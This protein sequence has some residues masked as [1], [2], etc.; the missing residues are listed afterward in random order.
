MKGV[1]FLILSLVLS[2]SGF[3]IYHGC[4]ISPSFYMWVCEQESSHCFRSLD[5]GRTWY[6]LGRP[7]LT[8]RLLYDIFF[9][10]DTLGWISA[11]GGYIFYTNDGGESWRTQ[12]QGGTKFAQRIFMLNERLGWIASGEAII[13]K[14]TNGGEEWEQIILPNPPFPADTVD[15]YGV[16]FIDSLTGW[17]VAGRYPVGDT[18]I[19]GQGYIA[20][21]SDGGTSWRLLLRDTIFDFFD[22]FFIDENEGW[23]VGGND[24]TFEACI[25]HTTDGGETWERQFTPTNAFYLRA[26]H[27]IGRKGWAS[28]MFGTI[29]YT[30]DGRNWTTQTTPATRTLF[31]IEFRDEEKGIAS[32]TDVALYT[33][34]GGRN[35]RTAQV[36]TKEDERDKRFNLPSVKGMEFIYDATGRRCNLLK[37]G[38]YFIENQGRIEK[39]IILD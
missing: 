10:D 23:V 28:G 9:L 4:A 29:L 7:N 31:D 12:N 18:F 1:L 30:S 20:K 2:L 21:S 22:C 17:A 11:E 8:E 27:F 3:P 37:K 34:D 26:C 36:G 16:F 32:G 33:I 38:I 13:L 19:N 15:F 6:D 5:L 24:Q 14:T 39:R 25:L 35:W